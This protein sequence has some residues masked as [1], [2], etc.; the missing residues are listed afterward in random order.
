[1]VLM[2]TLCTACAVGPLK[3]PFS[4][5]AYRLEAHLDSQCYGE[6]LCWVQS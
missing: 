5:F 4:K 1:M 3:S 2:E 6:D